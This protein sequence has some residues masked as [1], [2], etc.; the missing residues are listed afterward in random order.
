MVITLFYD[1]VNHITGGC[2]HQEAQAGVGYIKV[3]FHNDNFVIVD[4]VIDMLAPLTDVDHSLCDTLY[5]LL[6]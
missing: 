2:K 6:Y 3:N 5:C 4:E 1:I